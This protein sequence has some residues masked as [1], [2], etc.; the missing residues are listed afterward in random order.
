MLSD[1]VQRGAAQL[2]RMKLGWQQKYSLSSKMS[3]TMRYVRS[4]RHAPQDV[5]ARR[6]RA[7]RQQRVRARHW[8]SRDR[9]EQLGARAPTART[10]GVD[11]RGDLLHPLRRI[12]THPASRVSELKR[13]VRAAELRPCRGHRSVA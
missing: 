2:L 10:A 7:L 3:D 6:A 12:G 8:R 5:S 9:V 13:R 11:R 4:E 1:W